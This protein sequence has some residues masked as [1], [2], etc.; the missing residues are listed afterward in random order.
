ML[1]S[2]RNGTLYIGVTSDL[3]RRIW[4][5]RQGL[6]AGFTERYAVHDLVWYELH[7]TMETAITR[8]KTMKNWNRDWKLA[9]IEEVNP[10]WRDLYASTLGLDSLSS[11][12]K[13]NT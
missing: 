8:E 4:Q 7:E 1:A 6:V 2:K 10:Q 11:Q 9:L 12:T 5:H 13:C 3:I